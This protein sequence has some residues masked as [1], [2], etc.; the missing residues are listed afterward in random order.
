MATNRTLSADLINRLTR[1]VGSA[2][3]DETATLDSAF[4]EFKTLAQDILSCPL[5]RLHAAVEERAIGAENQVTNLQAE[6]TDALNNVEALL[7]TNEE[8]TRL[9]S[10]LSRLNPNEAPVTPAQGSS[11]V[12]IPDPPI[13]TDSRKEWEGWQLQMQLK[14]RANP[15]V[16]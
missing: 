16:F 15:N 7:T 4:L 6:L 13:F 2:S 12:K 11:S 5:S 9:I 14:L 3:W 8:K 1:I 10:L